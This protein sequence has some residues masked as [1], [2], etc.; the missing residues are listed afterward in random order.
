MSVIY[1]PRQKALLGRSREAVEADLDLAICITE[2]HPVR[3]MLEV[4][5]HMKQ[6]GRDGRQE[7]LLLRGRTVP[8]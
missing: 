2:R 1:V 3:D 6:K 5:N 4:R 8:A 7:N